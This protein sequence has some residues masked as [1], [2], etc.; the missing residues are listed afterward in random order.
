MHY[1]WERRIEGQVSLQPRE[2]EM[3]LLSDDGTIIINA[4]DDTGIYGTIFFQNECRIVK[5]YLVTIAEL[6]C[7]CARIG[8]RPCDVGQ[9][10]YGFIETKKAAEV[11][12]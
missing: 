4:V 3:Y 11:K 12:S 9:A 1:G 2:H 6:I 10:V 5:E 8:C 7:H